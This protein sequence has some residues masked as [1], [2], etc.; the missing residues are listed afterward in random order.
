[1]VRKNQEWPDEGE[2]IIGTVYKVLNYGAFAKLEEY[3]GKEAFIHIS[4]VSSGWV[5]NIRDHVREN[6]KIV[7][8][9]LRVNP[10][11][12]HVDAS[13]KRIREDQRTKKIQ[14]WK[15]EQKAEKFLEL[16]AK[17]LG[18]SLND[19]IYISMVNHIYTAVVRAKDDILVKTTRQ[20]LI[21]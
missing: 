12:G 16:S 13:L 15:I 1:M 10:K 18:K 3:H 2:L 6:Q 14:H 17:S 5:K 19:N 9:V 21:I 8:R 4:E 11:K 7:C 20:E